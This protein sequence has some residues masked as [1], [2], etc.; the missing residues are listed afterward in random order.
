L[1]LT[2]N[3]RSTKQ[4]IDVASRILTPYT[5][6]HLPKSINR[7]GKEP[8]EEEFNSVDDLVVSFDKQVSED[9]K[10]I[11][12]SI[13]IICTNASLQNKVDSLLSKKSINPDQFIKLDS[14]KVIH[15]LPRG[16]YTMSMVDCKGLEFAKVYVL[17]M[18]LKKVKGARE[19]RQAFVAVTRAMNE[20]HV[21]GIK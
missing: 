7:M 12:K 17:G 15:Y 6:K 14:S 18:N 16:I 13:G 9:I 20:L 4:I 1:E 21:L 3:Y 8:V 2:T 19:A 10:D 11:D 5:D